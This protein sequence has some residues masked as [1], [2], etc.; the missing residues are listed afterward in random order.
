MAW[1]HDSDAINN[2]VL[3]I[4]KELDDQHARQLA[5]AWAKAWDDLS[6]E[7]ENTIRGMIADGQFTRAKI[8]RSRRL[9]NA[10]A[11]IEQ[12]LSALS[13][14]AADGTIEQ[15]RSVVQRAGK[16]T[17][18]LIASM[19]PPSA[20]VNGWARVDASQIDAIITRTT[21]Q[22]TKLSWPLSFE[23]TDA[24]RRELVRGVAV[25][26][27]PRVTA[28]RIVKRTETIFNGGLSRALTIARTETLDAYR[29]AAKL[30]EEANT[31]VLAGW[32]WVASLTTRTCP[33]C[34]SMHGR[35][36]E[37]TDPGPN[38]HQNCRCVRAPRTKT[39]RELGFTVDEPGSVLPNS[40]A[41]FRQLPDADQR[42]VLGPRRWAAYTAGD[43]PIG[44]WATR[45]E[46][47]GWRDS[48]VTSRAP[49][50]RADG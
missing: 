2:R 13:E 14:L 20:N 32:T 10:L 44:A 49:A 8:M 27:N 22:I 24:M 45:R 31:D 34:W 36:F 16:T 9:A 37:T 46:N 28:R 11:L 42:A 7:F 40:Q 12:R 23:A 26:V 4:L 47:P 33:A 1:S 5:E 18:Q 50:T 43:Y 25:G 19:L 35:E 15:L 21:E 29:S 48:W 38:G 39:W 17:D 30:G 41:T 6:P 3:A